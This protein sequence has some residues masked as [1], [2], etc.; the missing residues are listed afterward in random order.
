MARKDRSFRFTNLAHLLT[1]EHLREAHGKVRR[2][3]AV[4]TAG[5]GFRR[6]AVVADARSG[7]RPT[8]TRS[9]NA[10]L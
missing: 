2:D 6:E 10:P 7:S 1:I 3:V 4:G 5:F 8:R 9:F